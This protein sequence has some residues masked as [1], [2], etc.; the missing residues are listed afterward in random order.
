M[1][2]GTSN[3]LILWVALLLLGSALNA[4]HAHSWPKCLGSDY[5][6][7]CAIGD[8]R[9]G[10]DTVTGRALPEEARDGVFHIKDVKH[11]ASNASCWNYTAG[12]S[13][14]GPTSATASSVGCVVDELGTWEKC[15]VVYCTDLPFCDAELRAVAEDATVARK[16]QVY[17]AQEFVNALINNLVDEIMLMERILVTD[18]E[19]PPV[20]IPIKR[21]VQVNRAED[22]LFLIINTTRWDQIIISNAGVWVCTHCGVVVYSKDWGASMQ[23]SHPYT[24]NPY[25]V[26]ESGGVARMDELVLI[27]DCFAV[28]PA[29]MML[30]PYAAQFGDPFTRAP[31]QEVFGSLT[32][33]TAPDPQ[34]ELIQPGGLA[35]YWILPD[36]FVNVGDGVLQSRRLHLACVEWVDMKLWGESYEPAPPPQLSSQA[37]PGEPVIVG[38][39]KS[40]DSQLLV[41]LGVAAAVILFLGAGCVLAAMRAR[42]KSAVP[43]DD[44]SRYLMHIQNQAM[45]DAWLM[46]LSHTSSASVESPQPDE[47]DLELEWS[48]LNER[49]CQSQTGISEGVELSLTDESRKTSVSAGS[50]A[51]VAINATVDSA[52]SCTLPL[53]VSINGERS[54]KTAVSQVSGCNLAKDKCKAEEGSAPADG[55]LDTDKA[56][57]EDIVHNSQSAPA[58]PGASRAGG[59]TLGVLSMM[60]MQNLV[61]DSGSNQYKV[62]EMVGSGTFAAC[63]RATD[64]RT[65]CSVVM[66]V[67]KFSHYTDD[68]KLEAELLGALHHPHI[69]TL[70]ESFS[71][72]NREVLVMDWYPGGDLRKLVNREASSIDED[73]V[74]RVAAQLTLAAAHIH[75]QKIVHR[76]IKLENVFLTGDGDVKVGDFGTARVI[77]DEATTFAGTPQCMAPE[78]L[79]RR[80]YTQKSDV[81]SIGTLLYELVTHIPLVDGRSIESVKAKHS[82]LEPEKTLVGPGGGE[83]NVDLARMIVAM[84][85]SDPDIRPTPQQIINKPYMQKAIQDLVA[86]KMAVMAQSKDLLTHHDGLPV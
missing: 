59:S 70:R 40:D 83:V 20:P 11:A 35:R 60:D 85:T 22:S 19:L 49:L 54:Y 27:M 57:V 44:K 9:D 80:P 28:D 41:W 7:T 10:V 32:E 74:W 18:K 47:H 56:T 68:F 39:S 30:I 65:N 48:M 53:D 37:L 21:Y 2:C 46:A 4:Q 64:T 69:A 33:P 78:V 76:D 34:E 45:L 6:A 58:V 31:G 24:P 13:Y 42:K 51:L 61:M 5:L 23:I 55:T 29:G 62:M 38:S 36:L 73:F 3:L 66:K 12:C 84:L 71:F 72:R 8:G 17:T 1:T 52:T 86:K 63:F 67:A 25:F 16:A 14:G 77:L 15:N 26:M 79:Q 50:R 75:A 81:W 43:P 82:N